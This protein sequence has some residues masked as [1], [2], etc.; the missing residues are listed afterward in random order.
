MAKTTQHEAVFCIVN[1]G[2]A[3]AVMDAAREAG[4]TGG[5]ILHATGTARP[6][7]ELTFGVVVQPQKEIV[8]ILVDVS[9]KD[10]VLKSLYDAV[11]LQTAGQGIAFTL[12]VAEVVGLTPHVKLKE[13]SD[14][15]ENPKEEVKEPQPAHEQDNKAE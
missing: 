14:S 12:P 2:F 1:E 9:I 13:D 3:E 10:A 4:A 8:M 7:S 6:D 11:G 5:T 15:S